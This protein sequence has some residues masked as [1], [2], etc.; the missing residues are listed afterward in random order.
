[1]DKTIVVQLGGRPDRFRLAA[2]AYDHLAGYLDGAKA[3]LHDDPD[4]AEVLADLER[5]LGDKLAARL[6]S[7]DRLM[8]AADIDAVLEEVG[9]VD[10]GR[11]PGAGEAAARSATTA[12]RRRLHR[13]RDGQQVAGVC[14]GLAAY[15]GIDVAWVRTLFL[16]AT[17]LTAGVF[18]LVYFGL[19]VILPI[20]PAPDA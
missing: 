13:I 9:A 17:T 8:T 20:E 15:T 3:R 16:V 14:N 7:G 1:M 18:A 2:D 10:T 6:A 4:N 19:A 5:S 12:G 11:E